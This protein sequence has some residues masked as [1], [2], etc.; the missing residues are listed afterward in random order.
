VLYGQ[1]KQYSNA[2]RS[3]TKVSRLVKLKNPFI[4]DIGNISSEY[5]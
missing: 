2:I 5:I 3:M 4:R 1:F